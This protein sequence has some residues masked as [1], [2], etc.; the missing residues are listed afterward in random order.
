MLGWVML[1]W[2]MVWGCL[3]AG[4]ILSFDLGAVYADMFSVE[5]H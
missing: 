5:I 1:E 2:S 3:G 4:K